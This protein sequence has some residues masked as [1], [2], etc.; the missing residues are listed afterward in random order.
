MH[1][2][3]LEYTRRGW[4]VVPIPH[5]SKNPGFKGWQQVRLSESDI[6]EH[7]NG[8]P[9]NIG[10]LTGEPSGW[11]VDI[12]L[13]HELAVELAPDFLPPTGLVFGRSGKPRSH[14]LYRVTAPL[15]TKKHRSKSAGMIVELRSTGAQ[16]VFPPSA[17]DSG[18]AIEWDGD[19]P[20][21]PADI[22]P[23]KLL[24]AVK[25]LATAVL[26]ELGERQPPKKP[27]EKPRER[28]PQ[29]RPEPPLQPPEERHRT[30][31]ERAKSALLAMRRM[32]MVDHNDGS[33]R[34]FAAACRAVEHDLDDATALQTIR[35]YEQGEPF[36]TQWSDR[37]VLARVR[38]AEKICQRGDA[39]DVDIDREGLFGLGSLDP[40][41]GKIILSSRRT[42]PTAEAFVRTHYA[43]VDGPT[44]YCHAGNLLSWTGNRYATLEDDAVKKHLQGWLHDALRYQYKREAKEMVLVPFESNPGSVKSALETIKAHTHLPATVNPPTWLGNAEEPPPEEFL[45]CK[46]FLLH[47]PTMKCR[48][49]TPRYFATNALDFDPDASAA[50]P[51]AW[52]EFLDQLLGED[53]EGLHLLQE[54]FGY[55][56]TADTSQ[57]K[58]LLIVGPK[59]S[60]KGTLARILGKLVGASNVCGPTTSSLASNFGLQPLVGKTLAIVSDARFSGENISTVVERLLCISGEDAV[61][62][63]R[64]F[65]PSVTLKLPTRF[66]FLSN[67]L[68]RMNDSSGALAGRFL[69]LRFTQSFYGRE[70]PHL[71]EK[72]LTELPGILNWAIE[73]WQRLHQRGRFV[74]PESSREGVEEMEDLSSPVGAFVRQCC[75]TGPGHRVSVDELYEAWKRWCEQEGRTK[76][77]TRQSFGRDLSAAIPGISCR[78]GTGNHRFY[79]GISLGG[80]NGF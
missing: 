6:A 44:L 76:V 16:T 4:S 61:S 31:N 5:R 38:D 59:R 75:T 64:K 35:Q 13:D 14:W 71:T 34:L 67:E 21:E 58:M 63:D 79:E 20:G 45:P 69:L 25:R 46:S 74:V 30:R 1:D 15:A 28:E 3:A 65:L 47:L 43:H 26:T 60:G 9:Q 52:L 22:D 49:P 7:F 18:E 23:E 33:S 66:M 48:E 29:Q 42:L 55:C 56:L 77:T 40:E 12:D 19:G 8:R 78:R 70:D 27:Q 24:E 68:P 53:I 72:L 36:P 57:Q 62:V 80:S 11:L 51:E 37:Q 39:F 50:P 41:S 17:H 2:V 73:G 54:W 10:V 32:R